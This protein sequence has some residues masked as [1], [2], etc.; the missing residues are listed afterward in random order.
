MLGLVLGLVSGLGFG[1]GLRLELGLELGLG[2]G[3]VGIWVWVEVRVRV[4]ARVRVR[5]YHFFTAF[6]ATAWTNSIKINNNKPKGLEF[7]L[8]LKFGLGLAQ[9]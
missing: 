4:V 2:L 8:R 1:L 5:L 9:G 3:L 7:C 6:I